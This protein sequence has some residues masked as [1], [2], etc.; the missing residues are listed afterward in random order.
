MS[1]NVIIHRQ[2]EPLEGQYD[3]QGNPVLSVVPDIT[4]AAIA[5][6]PTQGD[7]TAT[8]S[9]QLSV[10]G[11]T[12]YLPFGTDIRSTDTV[13]VRGVDGW[14]VEADASQAD[15]ASPFTSWKPGAVA[16][17]SRAS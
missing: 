2:G 1:E 7:E 3:A 13:T 11:Y 6:A 4:V 9:G 15:W 16:K 17:V 14:H 12:L 10:N 5:I 8:D